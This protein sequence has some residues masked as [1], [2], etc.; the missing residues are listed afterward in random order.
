MEAENKLKVLYKKLSPMEKKVFIALKIVCA[1]TY[2]IKYQEI[3]ELTG[4]RKKQIDNALNR[5][6]GKANR[7]LKKGGK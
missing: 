6:R 3:V 2:D 1:D 7:F 5:I 4:L